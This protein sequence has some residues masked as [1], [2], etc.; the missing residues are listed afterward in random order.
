MRRLNLLTDDPDVDHTREGLTWRALRAGDKLGGER[1]GAALYDLPDG[2]RTWPYHYH[3]GV[4]E[5]LY[6]VA[7]S[8]TVRTPAGEQTLRPGDV[9][10]FPGNERGAHAVTGPG[11][12]LILSA[13]RTPSIAVYPD[14]DK[15]GLRPGPEAGRRDNVD[16]RRQDAVDYWEGE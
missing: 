7:G 1:I 6:V 16:F 5:W 8:P 12:V 14:S 9:L 10:C 13:N 3:H 2:E 4:E 15:I 11:K